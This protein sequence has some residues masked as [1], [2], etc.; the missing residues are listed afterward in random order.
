MKGH[1]ERLSDFSPP[2]LV[3]GFE[4]ERL[5]DI[6]C[7]FTVLKTAGVA[8][9]CKC[10]CVNTFFYEKKPSAVCNKGYVY[11]RVFVKASRDLGGARAGME[12]AA[13]IHPGEFAACFH[14]VL[15][16]PAEEGKDGMGAGS[17]TWQHRVGR[18]SSYPSASSSPVSA[19]QIAA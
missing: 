8:S 2:D 7:Y 12:Q 4:E 11:T 15:S 10:L 16:Q 14:T 6:A 9:I 18:L 19:A 5:Q 1:K 3:G 17:C 13:W